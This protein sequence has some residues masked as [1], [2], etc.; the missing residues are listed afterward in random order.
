MLMKAFTK[1]EVETVNNKSPRFQFK[2]YKEV[3]GDF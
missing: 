2:V 1:E 3:L